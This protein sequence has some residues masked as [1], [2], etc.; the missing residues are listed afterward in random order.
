MYKEPFVLYLNLSIGMILLFMALPSLLNRKEDLKVRMA[1]ALIFLSVIATM[2]TNV[3][4]LHLDNYRLG[5]VGFLVLFISLS[6]GPLIYYYI[7]NLLGSRVNKWFLLCLLPG[8]LSVTYGLHLAFAGD[9]QQQLVFAQILSGDHLLYEVINFLTLGLTLIYCVK[10]WLFIGRRNKEKRGDSNQPYHIK[11]AWAREFVIYIFANVFIFMIL[12]LVLTK[13]FGIS[14]MDADLI[15]MPVF[16]LFVYLL[17]GVRSMM[18]HKD[19]ENRL[20]ISHI[21]HDRQI[22]DQ[23]LDISRELHD[24]MGAQLTFMSSLL[25]GLKRSP[26]EMDQGVKDKIDRLA[27]FSDH[28]I[29][30]LKNT[31]WVLHTKEITLDD[32]RIK[33]LN[34]ISNAAE[35]KEELKFNF[36][37]GVA[38][39]MVLDSKLAVNLFRVIQEILNNAIKHAQAAEI[40][41]NVQ[42]NQEQLQISIAD[43]GQGFNYEKEKNRSFG[44]SNI[45]NRVAALNGYIDLQTAAGEGTAYMIQI[46]L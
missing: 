26:A 35:A 31:L 32:L 3:V 46:K 14:S 24:S 40:S 41:I 28:S 16:M 18:M 45:H 34:L 8:S 7:K 12:M 5:F 37:F 30:E 29:A 19:F 36:S 21:E 1:F 38:E 17:V 39:N 22:K 33:I 15:G 23:R 11:L 43:N 4:I 9:Q 42:Q 2:L 44:L 25:D 6:F 20:L 27:E 13:G 10:A